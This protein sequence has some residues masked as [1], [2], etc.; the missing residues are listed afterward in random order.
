MLE[1]LRDTPKAKA[2]STS[3]NESLERPTV[4][5]KIQISNPNYDIPQS[6]DHF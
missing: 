4:I 3:A 5:Q 1:N 2:K 6:I